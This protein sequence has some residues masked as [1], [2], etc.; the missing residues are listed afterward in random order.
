ME[1]YEFLLRQAELYGVRV[2]E[3]SSR[4]SGYTVNDKLI[5]ISAVDE[6]DKELT[7][8]H[9]LGHHIDITCLSPKHVQY[10]SDMLNLFMFWGDDKARRSVIVRERKAWD[11]ARVLLKLAGFMDWRWFNKTRCECLSSFERYR[12]Q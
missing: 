5:H 6:D 9:E 4:F 3:H 2:I 8:A 12:P 7:L 10:C 1:V 11:N